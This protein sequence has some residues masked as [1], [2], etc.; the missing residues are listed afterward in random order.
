MDFTSK[1]HLDA[2]FRGQVAV[3]ATIVK[4]T[5]GRDH[6]FHRIGPNHVFE[7]ELD[8]GSTYE[9]STCSQGIQQPPPYGPG[10]ILPLKQF[11]PC[12]THLSKLFPMSQLLYL[13]VIPEP[14]STPSLPSIPAHH[15]SH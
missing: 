5:A 1:N 8:P 13:E 14:G 12:V 2:L 3:V 10:A 7:A 9:T 11:S 6:E 4:A 15:G